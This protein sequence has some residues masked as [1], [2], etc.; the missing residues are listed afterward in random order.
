MDTLT[1]SALV[2][3]TGKQ[4]ATYSLSV[5]GVR[6]QIP[7]WPGAYNCGQKWRGGVRNSFSDSW[8]YRLFIIMALTQVGIGFDTAF[9]FTEVIIVTTTTWDQNMYQEKKNYLW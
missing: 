8:R 9:V 4:F 2:Q 6:F 5:G 7:T 1:Y 3:C